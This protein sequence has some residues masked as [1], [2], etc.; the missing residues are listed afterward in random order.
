MK[1]SLF[2][3][4]KKM[5]MNKINIFI[6]D[7][8]YSCDDKSFM[9]LLGFQPSLGAMILKKDKLIVILDS[10][11]FEKTKNIDLNNIKKITWNESLELILVE[12]RNTINEIKNNINENDI[13]E[14]EWKI[15]AEYYEELRKL[16]QEITVL[17]WWF[18]TPKRITK[19]NN[20]KDSFKKAISIIDETF[21]FIKNLADNWKLNWKT[22][23]EVRSIILEQIF[24]NGWS[25]ESFDSI[26]A[27]W[28]NSSTPHHS[29]WKTKISEGPLLI[30][31]WALYNWYC[32]D[33]TRTFWIWEKKWPKYDE[34]IKIHKI[35]K[36]AHMNAFENTKE[37]MSWEEIDNLTRDLIESR[38]YMKE[39]TH[40]TWHW[41]WLNIHESPFIKQWSKE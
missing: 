18:F 2:Q 33:F 35:V 40:G 22:E 37:N 8:D 38:W 25:W 9:Y 4:I 28:A 39:Y 21:I 3:L 24:K 34:F 7:S 6:T 15:A 29:T 19:N 32:S 14:I 30:D 12:S 10:R 11:Y 41:V 20:E 5:K 17:K 36:D 27:F 13:I 23:L 16:N 31:M 26:V 1:I